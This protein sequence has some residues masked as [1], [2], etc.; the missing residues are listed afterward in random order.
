MTLLDGMN[1]FFELCSHLGGRRARIATNV[2]VDIGRRRGE[3]DPLRP[4][5]AD[6]G[7]PAL[8]RDLARTVVLRV[9][10]QPVFELQDDFCR[11]YDRAAKTRV[12]VRYARVAERPLD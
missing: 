3:R 5:C 7:N 12:G 10:W 2:E 9:A 1:E 8:R 11:G 4:S 6:C